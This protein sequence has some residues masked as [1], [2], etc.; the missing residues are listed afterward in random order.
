METP[1]ANIRTTHKVVMAG[2]ALEDINRSTRCITSNEKNPR[3]RAG[4][5]IKVT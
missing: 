3:D 4:V 2:T 5:N 1:V